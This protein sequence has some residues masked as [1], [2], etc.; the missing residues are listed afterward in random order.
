MKTAFISDLHVDVN[1]G[2][3]VLEETAAAAK[4]QGAEMIIVAGD[5]T[6]TP[7]RSVGTAR[8][9]ERMSGLPVFYVPGNHDL[10]NKNVPGTEIGDIYQM[11]R[12]DPRCLVE[13]V[14]LLDGKDGKFALTGDIGWYDYSFAMDGCSR[15]ELDSMTCGDRTW[16]DRL[17]NSWTDDNPGT[18]QKRLDMLRN[19]LRVCRDYPVVVVTHMA[20]VRELLLSKGTKQW[21][22]FQAFLGSSAYEDL[23]HQFNVKLSVSGHIHRRLTMEKEGIN[24]ICPCLGHQREWADYGLGDESAAAQVRNAMQVVDL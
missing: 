19:Q 15:Q 11:F 7:V 18:L 13:K 5:L 16:K 8:K 24:Y 9:L 1:Q 2:Q 21:D 4:E 10:W 17:Y 20:P 23:F 22:F 12:A 3:P 14:M 6:E